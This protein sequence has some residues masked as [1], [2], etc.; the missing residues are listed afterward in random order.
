MIQ[1]KFA[2]RSGLLMSVGL[3]IVFCWLATVPAHA[4][5][6]DKIIVTTMVEKKLKELP[7]G[8]LYWR[9]ENFASLPQAEAAGGPTS[10]AAE[11]AGKAWLFTLGPMGRATPGGSKVSE[12]GPVRTFPASE[13]ILQINTGSGPFG[14]NTPV[15]MHPGSEAF[16]VLTGRLSQKTPLGVVHVA[17]GH[18]LPGRGPGTPMQIVSTG[19]A[20]LMVLVMSVIDAN[21]SFS[22][23]AT[24]GPATVAR[25]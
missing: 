18:S 24:F 25:E 5:P 8:P 6:L 14:A 20:D 9:L 11:I 16:Y 3:A 22:S 17:A 7:D 13:Y 19:L 4:A 2:L 12:I 23:L 15:L 1:L 21:A 10:V